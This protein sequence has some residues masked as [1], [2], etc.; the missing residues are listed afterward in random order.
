MRIPTLAP[1]RVEE[2]NFPVRVK[3]G[4]NTTLIALAWHPFDIVGWDGGIYPYAINIRDFEPLTRRIHTMPHEQILFGMRGAA[5][6]CLV[7][8]VMDYH[9]ISIPSP[10]YHSSIDVDE[11]VFNLADNFLGWE[12]ASPGIMTFH[13]RGLAHGP[14]PGT[15]EGSIGMKEFDGTAIMVDCVGRLQKTIHAQTCDDP[16][17]PYIWLTPKDAPAQ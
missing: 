5:I 2:G 14:K 4:A 12:G 13:P 1:P 9:P 17:Y 11:V 6:C 15:Y 3:F 10:P 7:P 16:A 8:R